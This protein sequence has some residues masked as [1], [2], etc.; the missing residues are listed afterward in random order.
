M[1]EIDPW[2][3]VTTEVFT[4]FMINTL[5]IDPAEFILYDHGSWS[6]CYVNTNND[7]LD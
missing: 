4:G 3:P 5:V 7:R 6:M 2:S 1:I